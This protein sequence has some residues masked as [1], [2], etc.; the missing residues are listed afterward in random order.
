MNRVALMIALSSAVVIATS[1]NTRGEESLVTQTTSAVGQDLHNQISEA[2]IGLDVPI[3]IEVKTDKISII[4]SRLGNFSFKIPKGF[5]ARSDKNIIRI[6]DKSASS[7]IAVIQP[8]D[9]GLAVLLRVFPW[10]SPFSLRSLCSVT[11]RVNSDGNEEVIISLPVATEVPLS[12]DV[13]GRY[14]KI[15]S[16]APGATATATAGASLQ[17]RFLGEQ[18]LP[19]GESKDKFKVIKFSVTKNPGEQIDIS[20]FGLN[21]LD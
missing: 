3:S 15:R 13:I 4:D 9:G 16:L 1:C 5:Q 20:A 19:I 10:Q 18:S 21:I 2:C 7:A 12:D 14:V 17:L 8:I 6:E 11:S